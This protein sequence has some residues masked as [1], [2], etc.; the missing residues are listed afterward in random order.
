[1]LE[2]G[3]YHWNPVYLKLE[4]RAR[5]S[6]KPNPPAM[7][8]R[9]L[10]PLC[11]PFQY[12]HS[13]VL[14]GLNAGFIISTLACS[15]QRPALSSGQ[16]CKP[17][18]EEIAFRQT[19]QVGFKVFMFEIYS[20]RRINSAL[21]ALDPPSCSSLGFLSLTVILGLSQGDAAL[22]PSGSPDAVCG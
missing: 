3:F 18:A 8:Q 16:N 6:A 4:R 20:S 2:P 9:K 5:L 19:S 22:I 21:L 10:S 12:I 13:M 11:F 14:H 17:W 7:E 15:E 1:M